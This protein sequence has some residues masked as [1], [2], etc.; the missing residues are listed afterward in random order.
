M[1]EETE[2]KKGE[3]TVCVPKSTRTKLVER[4]K[5]IFEE[6]DQEVQKSKSLTNLDRYSSNSFHMFVPDLKS[7]PV[8]YVKL[9]FLEYLALLPC[10]GNSKPPIRGSSSSISRSSPGDYYDESAPRTPESTISSRYTILPP[11]QGNPCLTQLLT[12]KDIERW[13]YCTSTS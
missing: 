12:D 10:Y 1:V 6:F 8:D 7:S 13:R 9:V 2:D 11:P 5:K 4:L 3:K